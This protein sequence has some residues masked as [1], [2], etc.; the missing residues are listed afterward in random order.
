M[1]DYATRATLN[2]L[3]LRILE[4]RAV[5]FDLGLILYRTNLTIF[6][7]QGVI[8]RSDRLIHSLSRTFVGFRSA[9]L[10]QSVKD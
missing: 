10:M 4:T 9:A 2:S 1:D 3:Y 6:E 5:T 7:S 8:R